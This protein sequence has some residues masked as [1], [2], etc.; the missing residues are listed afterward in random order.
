MGCYRRLDYF[1]NGHGAV[2]LR[3]LATG[4]PS[5]FDW[6][7]NTSGWIANFLPNL[8][9]EIGAALTFASMVLVYWP[10]PRK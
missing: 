7:V 1:N 8:E 4:N 10:S 6:R 9:S 2:A 3:Y 5:F